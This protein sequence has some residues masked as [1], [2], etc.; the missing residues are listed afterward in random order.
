MDPSKLGA[1]E[2][3]PIPKKVKEIQRFMGFVNFYRRFIKILAQS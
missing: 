3:W 1:I 2:K